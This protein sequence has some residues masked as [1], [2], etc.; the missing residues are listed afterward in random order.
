[1][2]RQNSQGP[3]INLENFDLYHKKEEVS[4]PV[5]LAGTTPSSS[6]SHRGS[7]TL[8]FVKLKPM[9]GDFDETKSPREG[10]KL[11]L[12]Q[13]RENLLLNISTRLQN[14]KEHATYAQSKDSNTNQETEQEYSKRGDKS[15]SRRYGRR[16]R[17]SKH[18][19]FTTS[20]SL[21]SSSE[22]L[23]YL[24]FLKECGEI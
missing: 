16:F 4:T 22:F 14:L 10:K 9:A 24:N 1:M 2:N 8:D 20:A 17:S 23:M 15:P 19:N 12:K 21:A 18:T 7:F 13:R 6:T 3:H 11:S 5:T